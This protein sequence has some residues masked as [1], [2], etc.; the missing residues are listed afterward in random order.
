MACHILPMFHGMGIMLLATTV[1]TYYTYA[2]QP[3]HYILFSQASCGHI[4][5][6]YKPSSPAIVPT[7]ESF[8]EGAVATNSDMIF[9]VPSIIEVGFCLLVKESDNTYSTIDVVD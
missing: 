1:R 3:F 5:S 4:I 8:F 6:T 2:D 7:P 9:S